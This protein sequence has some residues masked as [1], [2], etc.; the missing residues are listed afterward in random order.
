MGV[1][2]RLQMSSRPTPH[3]PQSRRGE[4]FASNLLPRR[5]HTVSLGCRGVAFMATIPACNC[6]TAHEV[7]I[8]LTTM[9]VLRP[10]I[11][12]FTSLSLTPDTTRFLP[13]LGFSVAL[14]SLLGSVCR[15]G[16]GDRR[17]R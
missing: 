13:Y 16:I 3:P 15:V 12:T 8:V 5:V 7:F 1:P 11:K 17:A 4:R 14:F 10:T 9:V 2:L 6:K